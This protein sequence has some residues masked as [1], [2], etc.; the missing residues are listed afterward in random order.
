MIDL[1]VKGGI[2]R[3]YVDLTRAAKRHRLDE[4][5]IAE[6]EHVVLVEVGKARAAREE[7]AEDIEPAI[8][9]AEALLK[10]HFD[11]SRR[12]RTAAK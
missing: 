8:R 11:A 4:K 3:A 1:L 10:E 9:I 7:F 6:I 2:V 5:D 12:A